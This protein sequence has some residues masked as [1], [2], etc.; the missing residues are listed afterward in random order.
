MCHKLRGDNQRPYHFLGIAHG[1]PVVWIT[2]A[3]RT[4]ALVVLGLLSLIAEPV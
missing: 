4:V 2:T 3:Q 1:S